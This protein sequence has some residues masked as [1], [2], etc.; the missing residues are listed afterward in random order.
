MLSNERKAQLDIIAYH[1]GKGA[2][3]D[4]TGHAP[5]FLYNAGMLNW[6]NSEVHNLCW[7]DVH[8]QQSMRNLCLSEQ[9]KN[10][11]NKLSKSVKMSV[12]NGHRF[13]VLGG[14]HSSAL[15]TWSGVYNALGP[16]QPIGLL[17]I[18]AH[19]DSHISQTSPSG[20]IHGMS[21]AHLLG[22][23]EKQLQLASPGP[24]IL[25]ENICFIGTRSYEPEEYDFL[26]N[27]NVKIFMAE[28]IERF[29]LERVLNQA[30]EIVQQGTNAFGVSL[31]LDVFDPIE[32]PGVGSPETGGLTTDFIKP[33]TDLVNRQECI[34]MELV[35]FNP[36]R[37][38]NGRTVE[39][40]RKILSGINFRHEENMCVLYSAQQ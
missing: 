1:S 36:F 15:G 21:V 34:G 2:P 6:L 4:R 7:I 24:A 30:L 26:C 3:D 27:L 14:D 16:A 17:W 10:N 22:Y 39:V 13:I 23:G 5:E 18:D 29:G 28:D 32:A 37:D 40:I 31:D 35:E 12:T 9:I 11:N 19:L 33:L 20:C 38:V 25:P 8:D